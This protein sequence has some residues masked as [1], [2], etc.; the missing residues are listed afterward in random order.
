MS[1]L[2]GA[3]D[4]EPVDDDILGLSDAIGALFGLRVCR[5]IPVG[6]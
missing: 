6:I 1:D 4:D 3:L 5:R 2:D